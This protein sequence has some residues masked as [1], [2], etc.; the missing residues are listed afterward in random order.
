M[1][2]VVANSV[3]HLI[4]NPEKVIGEIFDEVTFKGNEEDILL[5]IYRR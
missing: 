1:D 2:T 3:L 5:T 4:L